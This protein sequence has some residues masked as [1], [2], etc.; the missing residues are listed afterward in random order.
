VS[1]AQKA[2]L[3]VACVSLVALGVYMA[4]ASRRALARLRLEAAINQSGGSSDAHDQEE[5]TADALES[6]R[7][8]SAEVGQFPLL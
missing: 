5:E 6:A 1:V 4:T 2:W 7:R 3:G 8:R